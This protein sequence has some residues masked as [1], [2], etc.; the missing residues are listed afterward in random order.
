MKL[1]PMLAMVFAASAA[2]L[3]VTAASAQPND[4]IDSMQR[5][6]FRSLDKNGDGYLTKSEVGHLRGY[7]QALEKADENRDGKLNLDEFVQAE[8]I[9]DR[10]RAAAYVGDAAL[11]AKVKTALFR[12]HELKAMDVNVETDQG[13]VLLSGWVANEAQR[14]KALQVA[15]RVEGVKEVKDGMSIK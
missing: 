6:K 7:A 5:E 14:K 3:V 1:R 11:T 2:S 10:Q 12:E 4:K 15:S 8:A 13:R 9:H